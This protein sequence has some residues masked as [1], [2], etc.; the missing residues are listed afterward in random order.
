MG[1]IGYAIIIFVCVVFFAIQSVNFKKNNLKRMIKQINEGWGKRPEREYKYDEYNRIR[2]FFDNSPVNDKGFKIDDI[3]W[4]DLSMDNIFK[5]LNNTNS[6]AGE[7][8]LYKLLRTVDHDEESLE[9]FGKLSDFLK[10][11]PDLAKELETKF[12]FMGRTRSISF[13]DFIH[14][15]SD[16]DKRTNFKHYLS[17]ALSFVAIGSFFVNPSLAIFITIFIVGYNMF[18]YYKDKNEVEVYFV[19]INYLVGLMRNSKELRKYIN[20]AKC[21]DIFSEYAKKIDE[22]CSKLSYLNRGIFLIS[23]NSVND[24]LAD[25]IL[26]YVR[27]I[28]HVDLIKFNSI[29][30]N[31]IDKIEYIDALYETMGRIEAAIAVASFK[32]MLQNEYECLCKPVITKGDKTVEFEEMYHPLISDAV[33]NSM[34]RENSV[35]LTGSNASG[36]STFLKT[37]AINGIFAQTINLATAKNFVVSRCHIYSSMALRDDLESN[38]SY[39]IVEIKS[40]KRIID[41]VEKDDTTVM[42]FIDEVLRGTNTVERIAAS[43][44]ILKELAKKDTIC[45]AATHDIELTK[46]LENEYHNY[47]FEEEVKNDDVLFNYLLKTGPATTRNAIKLLKVIGYN[48]DIISGAT[49]KALNFL[50]KGNWEIVN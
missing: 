35:L 23:G 7:E 30:R 17:I 33:K 44:E 9:E 18:S 19:C 15:L 34:N 32:T 38:E 13:Y 8:Y 5:L 37:V 11:N 28:F 29:V 31:T 14:R 3:T 43:S 26:E 39:Y 22:N 16:L 2:Y 36:K 47:H 40:L 45:F 46:I 27:M 25:I 41:A 50:D 1:V 42:C 12:A 4:N 10:D 48:D 24:S 6:S 20:S 49:N 21:T